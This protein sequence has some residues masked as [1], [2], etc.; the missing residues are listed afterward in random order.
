MSRPLPLLVLGSLCLVSMAQATTYMRVEK[1]GT[2]TYSDRPLPGGQPVDLQPAQSYA[3]PAPSGS[4][5]AP[6]EQQADNFTYQSCGVTPPNNSTFTNPES[7]SIEVVSNPR[8]RPTDTVIMTVDGQSVGESSYTMPVPVNRGTH[9]VSITITDQSGRQVCSASS[10]F[11]VIR[12]GVN[13]PAN[14]NRPR[15]TPR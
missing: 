7:I 13:S 9:T 12:P 1:D 3:A 15:P 14:P 8:V 5:S 10:A 11:H 6:S 2:K 4:S